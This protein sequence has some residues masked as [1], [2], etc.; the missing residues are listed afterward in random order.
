MYNGLFTFQPLQ[1]KVLTQCCS[2]E[3]PSDFPV[4]HDVIIKPRYFSHNVVLLKLNGGITL[5]SDLNEVKFSHN[6]VLLKRNKYSN[7]TACD[8]STVFSHNVVL[9]KR[10]R[11]DR[12][13]KRVHGLA[14]EVFSHNVVLLKLC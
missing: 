5:D 11:A 9:L 7:T 13:Y 2:T 3:T 6:V 4:E 14:E 10:K 12:V 8:V 1:G